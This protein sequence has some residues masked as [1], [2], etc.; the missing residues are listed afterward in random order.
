MAMRAAVVQ[1]AREVLDMSDFCLACGKRHP[2]AVRG[3]ILT[4]IPAACLKRETKATMK[5]MPR[6]MLT[7]LAQHPNGLSKGQILVHTGYRASGP[8]SKCF[9]ELTRN[10]WIEADAWR[11]LITQAGLSALGSYEPLPTGVALQEHLLNGSKL[12]GMEKKFLKSVIDAYPKAIG[13]GTILEHTGYAASGPVS[14]AFALL[15]ARGYAVKDGRG[16]LKAADE[17][18]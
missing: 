10:G 3:G 4:R 2:G 8:V 5:G 15:V 18:F 13:K 11:L 6:S 12:S 1:G 7:A 16:A 14:K 9:A 17:L